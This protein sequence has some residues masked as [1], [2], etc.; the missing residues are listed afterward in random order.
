MNS[1]KENRR[2]NRVLA[3]LRVLI[4]HLIMC[5]IGMEINMFISFVSVVVKSTNNKKGPPHMREPFYLS[6]Y[7]YFTT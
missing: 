6:T 1:I 4:N 5:V 3:V 7:S 2:T